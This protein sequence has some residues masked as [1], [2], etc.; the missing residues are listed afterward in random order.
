MLLN[1]ESSLRGPKSD[2][3]PN[4]N[5]PRMSVPIWDSGRTAL[6]HPTWIR[7]DL[8]SLP[9]TISTKSEAL[10]EQFL[11]EHRVKFERVETQQGIRTPDYYVWAGHTKIAFELKEIT[12]DDEF[13]VKDPKYPGISSSSRTVGDHI[14]RRIIDSAKQVQFGAQQGLPSVLLIYN[15]LDY[16]FQTFGTEPMD[17]IAAM[18]GA[19]T[20]VLDVPNRRGKDW[21]N[22]KG[23]MLQEAKNTSFSAVGHICNRGRLAT[24]TVTLYKNLFAK[25][26]LPEGLPPCFDVP[27][28]E[29]A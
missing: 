8:L 12:A 28:I 11:N 23:R 29:F 9:M 1:K 24:T 3:A 25:I 20:M 5:Q 2:L 26:A 17:F 10:F 13:D 27:H 22:G 18:Y 21:Y 6:S 7:Y 4:H 19:Y 16:V 14:R 15:S